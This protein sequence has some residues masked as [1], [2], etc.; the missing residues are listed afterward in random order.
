MLLAGVSAEAPGPALAPRSVTGRYSLTDP[1]HL[2][3]KGTTYWWY[4][5]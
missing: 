4:Q 1:H 5:W 3:Q 2:R